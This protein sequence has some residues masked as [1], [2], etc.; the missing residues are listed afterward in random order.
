MSNRSCLQQDTRLQDGRV[1][2]GDE[3]DSDALMVFASQAED[4]CGDQEQAQQSLASPRQIA[5]CRLQLWF[6]Q[7]Q[8][9]KEENYTAWIPLP[10]QVS[11]PR[12]HTVLFEEQSS[13]MAQGD[14]LVKVTIP[15]TRPGEPFQV[16]WTPPGSLRQSK[17]KSFQIQVPEGMK[18]G[19]ELTLRLPVV[20]AL[21][22][23][24][25]RDISR[26][27]TQL[28]ALKWSRPPGVA[29][30]DVPGSCRE[31][32]VCVQCLREGPS[33]VCDEARRQDRMERYR[34]IRGCSMDPSV[35]TIEEGHS[36][37]P[38]GPQLPHLYRCAAMLQSI[39]KG[40]QS[41]SG[42]RLPEP[43]LAIFATCLAAS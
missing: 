22:G 43:A 23:V 21:D 42:E 11:I 17:C 7:L 13:D 32:C 8:S 19:D 15:T 29:T 41:A 34:W 16:D 6:R 25:R 27:L 31:K 40:F 24:A 10:C 39:F 4:Q 5:A 2:I 14:Q 20:L 35:R 38:H 18:A 36:W 9:R 28:G 12:E 1:A 30:S 37:W 33:W 3:Q 26:S